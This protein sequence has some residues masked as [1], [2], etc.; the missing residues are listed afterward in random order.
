MKKL[1]FLL[2]ITYLVTGCSY[3][4]TAAVNGHFNIILKSREVKYEQEIW[5]FVV[6]RYATDPAYLLK[7]KACS[8]KTDFVQAG[9]DALQKPNATKKEVLGFYNPTSNLV[10][11]VT[12]EMGVLA[13]EYC[14]ALNYQLNINL[15]PTQN[16]YF[17][18][19]VRED[20]E[21][22]Q[23][24]ERLKQQNRNLRMELNKR[25]F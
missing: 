4:K 15:T 23:E 17:C 5:E 13:H 9:W 20:Y 2:A 18:E 14:H 22:I 10:V 25:R 16:E 6:E 21:G 7:P 19:R 11:Y 24:V 8:G 12:G 3:F 1:L